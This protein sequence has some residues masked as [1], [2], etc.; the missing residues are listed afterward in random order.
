MGAIAGLVGDGSLEEV[1][2]MLARM[3]HR[4]AVVHAWSPAA[5]VY[6]GCRSDQGT[7]DALGHLAMD[8]WLDEQSTDDVQRAL[9][10]DGASGLG[11]IRGYFSL[12]WWDESRKAVVLA[13]DT[14]GFKSLYYTRTAARTVFA[15]EYKAL[16][17]LDDVRAELDRDAAQYYLATRSFQMTQPLLKHAHPVTAGCAVVLR[18]GA[19]DQRSYWESQRKPEPRTAAEF[20]HEA[21]VLLERVTIRQASRYQRIGITLSG[22]LDS[23]CVVG[24][25]RKVRP[26]LKISSYTVGFG[27]DDPEAE[28]GRELAALFGCDHKEIAFDPGSIPR[29]LPLLVWLMEDCAGREEALLQHQVLTEAARCG[30]KVVFGGYGADTLFAGMPRYRLMRMRESLP[31]LRRPLSELFQYTQTGVMPRSVLGRLGRA[32]LGGRPWPP[33]DVT[34]ASGPTCVRDDLPLDDFIASQM[35]GAQDSGYLEPT[36]ASHGMEIRDPFQSTEMLSLAL[37]M[38]GRLNVGFRR[39]KMVLREAVADLLPQRVSRRRKSL[40]RVQH[41]E[42]ISEILDGM[43]DQ[44]LTPQI[45]R[46]RGVVPADYVERLRTRRPGQAYPTEQLYR[47]WTLVCLEIWQRHFIDQRGRMESI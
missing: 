44:L 35:D 16:L 11:G 2:A 43:A 14:P 36:L 18:D 20:A 22:G 40:Q 1:R 17:A 5:G 8:A 12:A 37:R 38:P 31:G 45:M 32:L 46:Q 30:E 34:G 15:S 25:L 13:C 6:F 33:P 42:Q 23:A 19:A 28:G 10:C 47:L 3:P 26:D 9:A 29:Q 41:D 39:Q 7:P 4:G 24:L 21:R 27:R